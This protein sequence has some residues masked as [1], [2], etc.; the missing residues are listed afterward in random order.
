MKKNIKMETGTDTDSDMDT[1]TDMNTYK[2]G[3]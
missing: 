1:V 3:T 2:T